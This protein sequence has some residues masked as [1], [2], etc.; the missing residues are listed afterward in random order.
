MNTL[1]YCFVHFE[2]FAIMI[3]VIIGTGAA[4]SGQWTW[5]YLL[6]FGPFVY[7]KLVGMS[8]HFHFCEVYD[9][10]YRIKN[11]NLKKK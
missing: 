10:A 9:R 7:G 1:K 2:V 11:I 4:E 8:R 5:A 3:S 6:I